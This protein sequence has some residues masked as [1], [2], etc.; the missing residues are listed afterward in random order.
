MPLKSTAEVVREMQR[1]GHTLVHAKLELHT[2]VGR[3][4]RALKALGLPA[5]V[6]KSVTV[7]QPVI[8]GKKIKEL[9]LWT[10]AEGLLQ[11]RAVVLA[12]DLASRSLERTDR[13]TLAEVARLMSEDPSSF[14]ELRAAHALDMPTMDL[15]AMVWNV[16]CRLVKTYGEKRT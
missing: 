1:K 5:I 10:S 11:L 14:G 3:A 4:G 9:T 8:G 15:E 16:R 6:R 12:A 13:F 2:T 7:L